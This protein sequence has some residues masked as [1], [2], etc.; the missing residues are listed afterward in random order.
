MLDR[1]DTARRRREYDRGVEGGKA[2]KGS[3]RACV[4]VRVRVCIVCEG[5]EVAEV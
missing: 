3:S 1:T 5:R 4:R 2:V